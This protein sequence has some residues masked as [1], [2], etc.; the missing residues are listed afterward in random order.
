LLLWFWRV[1]VWLA[2]GG[3]LAVSAL[4]FIRR[5]VVHRFIDR[6]VA[7]QRIDVLEFALRLIVSLAFI[8]VSPET[9]A[10]RVLFWCGA[11]LAITA[12]PL[13]LVHRFQRRH[14]ARAAP[15]AKRML[16]VMGVLGIALAGWIVWATV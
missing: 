3:L 12:L 4:V 7:A 5:A 1:V 2:A 15:F 13:T 14:A 9:T 8:A 10:P 11:G 6:F 16:P